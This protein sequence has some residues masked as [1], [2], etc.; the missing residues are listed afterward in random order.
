MADYIHYAV[1]GAFALLAVLSALTWTLIVVKALLYARVA[2]G[3]RR[4]AAGRGDRAP[5]S[6]PT[7]D[8]AAASP[9]ARLQRA[10]CAA[11]RD[12]DAPEP[13]APAT[14]VAWDRRDLLERT[15]AR[16]IR[17]ERRPL[18]RGLIVLA[19]IANVAPFVGLF[20][21]VFGIVH[22]LQSMTASATNGID[23]IAGPIGQAL[24]ATGIGI[25]VAIPA[26]LAYNLFLRQLKTVTAGLD[27]FGQDLIALAEQRRFR[28]DAPVHAALPAASNAGVR[29]AAV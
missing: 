17:R 12:L 13:H 22:T 9:N 11:L 2:L 10:V 4:F 1:V 18:E 27:E 26:V 5:L 20:G 19:S 6:M 15:L 16:A 3:N 23:A 8:E 21:T 25:G 24:V 28:I 7:D 14:L 29:R